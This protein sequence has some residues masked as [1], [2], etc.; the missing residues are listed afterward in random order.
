MSRSR[1]RRAVPEGLKPRPAKPQQPQRALDPADLTAKG[2]RESPW[3]S[4][5]EAVGYLGLGSLSALYRL[6]RE[7]DL[8]YGRSGRSYRFHKGQLDQWMVRRS[9]ALSVVRSA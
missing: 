4:A 6:I 2:R 5:H 8:P 7:W 9:G 1:S 3:I